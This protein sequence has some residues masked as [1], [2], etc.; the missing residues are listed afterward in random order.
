[1][2]VG[3]DFAGMN[4]FDAHEQGTAGSGGL[5]LLGYRDKYSNDSGQRKLWGGCEMAHVMCGSSLHSTCPHK[6]RT[7]RGVYQV[8]EG[9][10]CTVP[11]TR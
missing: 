3:R 7:T 4:G 9:K 10:Y 11:R 8:R 5:G 2:R 1:M 6:Y